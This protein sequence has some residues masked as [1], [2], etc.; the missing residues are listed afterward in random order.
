MASPV[1]IG[2]VGC[3]RILNAH[4]NGVKALWDHGYQ[5]LRI[6]AL[7][8]RQA[9]EALRHRR[10]GEGPAPREPLGGVLGDP[11]AAPHLYVSDLHDDVLPAVYTDWRAML[12]DRDLRLDAVVVLTPIDS[13]HTIA[14][15]ALERGLHVLVEKPLAITVAAGRRMVEAAAAAGRQLAVAEGVRFRDLNRMAKWC[16]D[17]GA[18]GEVQ[19]VC[20]QVLGTPWSPDRAVGGSAWRHERLRAG[21]GVTLD[22]GVHLFHLL[23]YLVGPIR[24]VAGRAA[25]L[26]AVRY[27]ERPTGERGEAVACDTDDTFVAQ[28]SFA[29]GA[30]GQVGFSTGLRGERTRVPL[31]LH[32][33]RGT[34]RAGQFCDAAGRREAVVTRFGTRAP[35][36]AR[37]ALLPF[38]LQDPFGQEWL[39][40]L[41]AIA[42]GRPSEVSGA[43]GLRDLAVAYAVL[44]SDAL[45]GAPVAVADVLDGTVRGYQT[46]VDAAVALA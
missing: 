29:S 38:D 19:L 27:L 28:L 20:E 13:H 21:G 4:L 34:L 46:A 1:R 36:A 45:G 12:D 18:I 3:G 15:A 17:A 32:G 14:L 30:L 43:V 44:E 35:A 31:T 26:E 42:T 6:V 10:R 16:L 22:R 2:V 37:E 24:T 8:A 5:D 33:S 23:E 11:L 39:S 7:V 9:A 41:R 25:C 40:W